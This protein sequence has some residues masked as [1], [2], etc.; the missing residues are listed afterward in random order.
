MEKL[1][2]IKSES[3]FKEAQKHLVG[4]VNSPVRSFG[5]VGGVPRFIK[6]A[7]G[8][9]ITDEDGQSYIDF[10]GSWGPMILG[11]N[12]PAVIKSVLAQL[13]LGT[14]FGAPT[15]LEVELAQTIKK[16]FPSMDKVRFTSSGTEA[17][18]SAIRLARGYTRRDRILKF[19]GGYHGHSDSLLV[20]AGSGATTFGVPSS[21][22]VPE[23]LARCTWVLPFN[24]TQKLEELF[25]TQGPNIAAVI[26]EPV[27]G[28]MGVVRPTEEFLQALRRLT[29]QSNTVLIFDEVMTGF[30]LGPS[31]AQGLFGITPDLTCLGKIIGAGFPVGVFGGKKEIMDL[32]APLGP[33]YQAGTLSGNPVA[34]AAGLALLKE[35]KKQNPFK[36]LDRITENLCG[37]IKEMAAAHK[38]AVQINQVGSMFTV[39]FSNEPVTNY[40][41]ALLANKKHYATFF[42]ALLD[43]GV[44]FPPSQFEAAF[45]STAHDDLL[46]K[47]TATAIDKA[48]QE[49]AKTL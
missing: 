27:C 34:M 18:M 22:G 20:A 48:F 11:H 38:I 2:K 45:V 28:N 39:F 29:T 33:V 42:H 6:E 40:F 23:I 7:Q 41:S 25:R 9:I 43:Q 49:V 37:K 36:H 17:T 47:K 1:K 5:G 4:G 19:A 14:S 10:V 32:L 30:R 12:H 15:S 46:M 3:L 26:L 44:Y 13:K 16:S 31:G 21:A 35:L 24:N 8:A